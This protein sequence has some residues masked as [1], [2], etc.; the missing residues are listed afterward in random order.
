MFDDLRSAWRQAVQN[1]WDELQEGGDGHPQI[2]VMQRE[3]ASARGE[4]RRLA[5]ERVRYRNRR[6]HEREQEEICLRR[7]RM[8]REIED[9]ETA[10]IAGRYA[11]RHRERA[12]ILARR[13][14]LIEQEE[15]LLGRDVEE[16][17]AALLEVRERPD[18][19]GDAAPTGVGAG[20]DP[21]AADFGRLEDER[22]ER[23]AEERLEELKRRM[24]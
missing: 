20:P 3:L 13:V 8:A 22:R 5:D 23:A 19:L 24:R 16:M 2:R 11:A 14:D 12:D 17:E 15:S 1:F 9:E 7:E 10:E 6:A 21:D 18:S 4:L